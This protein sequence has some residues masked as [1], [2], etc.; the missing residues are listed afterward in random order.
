[1]DKSL[2]DRLHT[3][4]LF[5]LSAKLLPSK[6]KFMDGTDIMTY[7][8]SIFIT[9]VLAYCTWKLTDSKLETVLTVLF[10]GLYV[11]IAWIYYGL[12]RY[13]FVSRK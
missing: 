10:G 1:M 12:N 2:M 6:E 5:G 7:S 3:D 13:R 9:I 4:V 8:F 11:I